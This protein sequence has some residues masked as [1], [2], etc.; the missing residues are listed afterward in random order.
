MLMDLCLEAE[1]SPLYE[2]RPMYVVDQPLYLNAVGRLVCGFA[3][4]VMLGHLQR[5]EKDLGRDRSRELRMGP[6]TLDLDILLCGDLVIDS[7]LLTIPHPRITERMFVLV[8]L[9]ALAPGLKDPRTGIRYAETLE[10]LRS[11][12]H[13]ADAGG[14][15]L[16]PPA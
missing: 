5:I 16:Y 8:P 1:L 14:V 7:P 4:K 13:E 12:S 11:E 3:P 15:Y 10:R 9:L 2:T 6:R